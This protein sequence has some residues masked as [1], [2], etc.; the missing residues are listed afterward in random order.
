M[1]LVDEKYLSVKYLI[2][3][4][5]TG[6]IF[7]VVLGG[8]SLRRMTAKSHFVFKKTDY[9]WI[10]KGLKIA[11]PFLLSTISLQIIEVSDRFFIDYFYSELDVGIYVFSQNIANLLNTIIATG[12]VAIVAPKLIS[13]S[14]NNDK[15]G[16]LKSWSELKYG[17]IIGGFVALAILC[18]AYPWVVDITGRQEIKDNLLVFYL[19]IA[20][21]YLG[22]LS[23][24]PYYSLYLKSLDLDLLKSVVLAALV[25]VFLNFILVPLFGV[26]GAALSSLLAYSTMFL[27]RVYLVK[28]C[29]A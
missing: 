13:T 1:C 28:R 24:I 21:V 25:N 6:S 16:S 19:L 5:L 15:D 23:L 26:T 4:W 20:A 18:L 10:G 3:F 29:H 27:T 7:S 12:V 2:L 11:F 17:I 8:S 14:M 22:L 9:V